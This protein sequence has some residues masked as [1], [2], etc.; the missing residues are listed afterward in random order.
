[1]RAGGSQSPD[2]LGLTET[3]LSEA[4]R[5]ADGASPINPGLLINNGSH[6]TVY[7]L[8]NSGANAQLTFPGGITTVVT[9]TL[10]LDLRFEGN[11]PS[12]NQ[13][14]NQVDLNRGTVCFFNL[15]P[16]IYLP[17]LLKN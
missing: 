15:N 4:A 11:D 12:L 5:A 10:D 2:P 9:A 13:Q 14:V 17:Q 3:N 16:S 1:V 6:R 7:E 8:F